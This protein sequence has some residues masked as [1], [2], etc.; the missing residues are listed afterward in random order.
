[1]TS[2]M[3]MKYEGKFLDE[4]LREVVLDFGLVP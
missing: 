3:R 1:M 2:W 4:R